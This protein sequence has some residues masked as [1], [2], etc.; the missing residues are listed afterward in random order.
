MLT[1]DRVALHLRL[2]GDEREF[3]S[4]PGITGIVEGR[5]GA[6]ILLAQAFLPLDLGP[7][8]LEQTLLLAEGLL[9]GLMTQVQVAQLGLQIQHIGLG[10]GHRRF[11]IPGIEPQQG[12]PLGDS[13]PLAYLQFAH[14]PGTGSRRLQQGRGLDLAIQGEMG[15]QGLGPGLEHLDLPDLLLGFGLGRFRPARLQIG[16]ASDTYNDE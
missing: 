14:L 10:L 7:G 3:L 13:I 5:F 11:E 1:V 16:E 15:S 9:I 8:Q 4:S 6:E 2:T 12:L